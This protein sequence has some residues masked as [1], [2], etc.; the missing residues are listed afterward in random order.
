MVHIVAGAASENDD[1]VAYCR[2]GF[3]AGECA[4]CVKNGFGIG[5]CVAQH[6]DF[7]KLVQIKRK[8]DVN[9][10]LRPDSIFAYLEDWVYRL[11][12]TAQ[13]GALRACEHSILY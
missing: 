7:D 10:L 8:G 4:N 13:F 1:F 3:C 5:I 11:S 2:D 9:D 6:G 12:H